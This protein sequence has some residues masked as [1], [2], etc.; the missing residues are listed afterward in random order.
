MNSQGGIIRT[1]KDREHP[2]RTMNISVLQ[3]NR[4]S[5]EARGLLGYLLSKPDDWEVRFTDLLSYAGPNCKEDRLRRILKEL[6]SFGYIQRTRKNVAHGKFEWVTTVFETPQTESA[7]M[8]KP[9][10]GTKRIRKPKSPSADFPHMAPYADSSI[11]DKPADIHSMDLSLSK[12]KEDGAKRATTPTEKKTK[13]PAPVVTALAD[14]CKIDQ[15]LGTKEQ[16]LQLYSTAKSL[17]EAG[18]AAGKTPEEIADTIRYVGKHWQTTHWKGKKGDLP[19]PKDIRE[20]W[21]AAIEARNGKN[22]HVAGDLPL[23]T[24]ADNPKKQI[25]TPEERRRII[26]A[27]MAGK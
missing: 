10:S 7:I 25:A 2:Y 3:D 6:E 9:A 21:R 22:G 13:T 18:A 20:D 23:M 26:E 19:W 27:R 17:Y 5:L 14:V 16:K 12:D 15:T 4:L 11:M 24:A 8:V 1:V